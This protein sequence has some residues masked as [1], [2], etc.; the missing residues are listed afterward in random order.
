MGFLIERNKELFI[1]KKLS[2]T[3]NKD[4]N[5]E[6]GKLTPRVERATAGVIT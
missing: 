6:A 5:S 1:S 4:P 3:V 2:G